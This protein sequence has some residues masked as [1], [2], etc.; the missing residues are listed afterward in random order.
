MSNE[1]QRPA[2]SPIEINERAPV[3]GAG[4]IKIAATPDV[5]WPVLTEIDRWPHW[6]PQVRSASLKGSLVEGSEFRWKAGPG[7]IRSTITHVDQPRKVA[8]TGRTLSIKAIHVYVLEPRNGTTLVKTKESYE[9][10]VARVFRGQLQK[11]LDQAL[12][13]GL[14]HLKAEAERR[15]AT[16][17]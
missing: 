13:E 5:V 1:A 9:G 17:V 6:N 14:Q 4:E 11:T 3:V 15:S 8:W 7:T 2:G 12:D 16:S 10:L